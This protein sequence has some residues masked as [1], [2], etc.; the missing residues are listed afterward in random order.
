M[1]ALLPASLRRKRV[2]ELIG[3]EVRR[4]KQAVRWQMS[5]PAGTIGQGGPSG[6]ADHGGSY[7]GGGSRG[8]MPWSRPRCSSSQGSIKRSSRPRSYKLCDRLCRP[9]AAFFPAVS[10]A[11][12]AYNRSGSSGIQPLHLPLFA[13]QLSSSPLRQI[14]FLSSL[15]ELTLASQTVRAR[16]MQCAF[17]H[18]SAATRG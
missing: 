8:P 14:I 16:P 3:E 10:Q 15:H 12:P 13:A 7:V 17:R 11:P 9:S 5:E 4:Q 18:A 1:Q 2:C 6:V